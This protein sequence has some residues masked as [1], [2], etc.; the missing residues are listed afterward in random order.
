MP[1]RAMPRLFAAAADTEF[2][3][4]CRCLSMMPYA[5]MLRE[6]RTMPLF[7]LALLYAPMMPMISPSAVFPPPDDVSL[8]RRH[9]PRRRI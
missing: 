2:A 5:D 8:R 6:R 4:R 3:P 9:E 7:S 1:R